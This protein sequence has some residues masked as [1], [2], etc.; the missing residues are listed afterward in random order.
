MRL[1][2]TLLKKARELILTS[3]YTVALTGAGISTPSGIP[4]FRSPESGLWSHY[5]PMAVASLRGFR[6]NPALF[7]EWLYPLAQNMLYAHPNPAHFALA[8]LEQLDLLQAV[9]T[10]NIDLLHSKAGSSTVY[11]IHGHMRTMTCIKCFANYELFPILERYLED[12]NVPTCEQCGGVLKPD[13]ILFGEQL[14]ARVYS[15]VKHVLRQADLMIVAGS[16][17]EVMPVADFPR[18]V[19]ERGGRLIIINLQPTDYDTLADVVIHD[20]VAVVLP[21]IVSLIKG[22]QND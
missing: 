7:Y 11:E 16:S 9:I 6:Y 3:Q 5:D 22:E 10:Q 21:T 2:D 1:I 12:R 18:E 14:P 15:Q 20:D 4:D 13:V 19:K 8:E 17:L